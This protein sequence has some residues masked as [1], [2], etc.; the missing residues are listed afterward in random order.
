MINKDRFHNELALRLGYERIL[1]D[2]RIMI[3]IDDSADP[4]VTLMVNGHEDIRFN[5]SEDIINYN[6]DG[7]QDLQNEIAF[8]FEAAHQAYLVASKTLF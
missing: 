2:K 1:N 7:V 4:W 6:L 8:L 5:P 3:S